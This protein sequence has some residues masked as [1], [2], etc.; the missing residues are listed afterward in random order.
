MTLTETL[1]EIKV[2][3]ARI[4][5]ATQQQFIGCSM[6]ND[7]VVY[8]RTSKT[9]KEFEDD[10]KSSFQ[11]ITDL[12]ARRSKLKTALMKANNEVQVTVNKESMTIATA[13][14][15]KNSIGIQHSLLMT[16]K[17]QFASAMKEVD[18]AEQAIQKR[19]DETVDKMVEGGTTRPNEKDFEVI[20]TQYEKQLKLSLVD[21]VGMETKIVEMENEI[22]EFM[23]NVDT[24]L[25]IANATHSIEI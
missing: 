19:Y 5:K 25:S 3:D 10:I 16:L 20:R 21:P 24:V 7:N 2:L 12:I 4:L 15:K 22:E 9:K 23:S 6:Q 1:K 11:S 13:I 8:P 14:E 17:N 18:K